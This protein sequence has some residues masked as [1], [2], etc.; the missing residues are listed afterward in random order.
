MFHRLDDVVRRLAAACRVGDIAAV[1][2][3]LDPAAVALCDGGGVVPAPRTPINGAE[4]VAELIVG[5]LCGRPGTEVTVVQ[6]NGRDGLLFTGERRPVAVVA[7]VTDD[8]RVCA[9][10]IV[11]NPAKLRGWS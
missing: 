5:L 11:L 1:R 2:E 8:A 7:V 10:W 4:A 6:I 3:V 9:L